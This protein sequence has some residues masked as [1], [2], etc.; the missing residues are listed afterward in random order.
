MDELIQ[1]KV[2]LQQPQGQ[3]A[4]LLKGRLDSFDFDKTSLGLRSN[5][6]P[7]TQH[8]NN[9]ID[10]NFENTTDPRLDP[11]YATYY[12]T[13]ARL[14]PRLPPPLTYTPG[15]SWQQQMWAPPSATQSLFNNDNNP[16]AQQILNQNQNNKKKLKNQGI[17][18][19]SQSDGNGFNQL[20]DDTGSRNPELRRP[21][22][23]WSNEGSINPIGPNRV[24]SPSR[25]KHL[26]DLIQDDFPRTPSPVFAMRQRLGETE[27][28]EETNRTHMSTVLSVLDNWED[29]KVTRS[30]STPPSQIHDRHYGI[31]FNNDLGM[32]SLNINGEEDAFSRASSAR[33]PKISTTAYGRIYNNNEYSNFPLKNDDTQDLQYKH[34]QQRMA[35]GAAVNRLYNNNAGDLAGIPGSPSRTPLVPYS[36]MRENSSQDQYPEHYDLR[37][38]ENKKNQQ[39]YNQMAQANNVPPEYMNQ[40]G[41][42][43]ARGGV[44]PG[45]LA[46]AAASGMS[47][48]K[49]RQILAQQQ[50]IW[51]REQMFR[52][53][54]PAGYNTHPSTQS[55]IANLSSVTPNHPDLNSSLSKNQNI[56]FSTNQGDNQIENTKLGHLSPNRTKK[57]NYEASTPN[58]DATV[59]RS[60]LLEDFRNNKNKKYEINDI[61]GSIVEFSG[62]QHGSRF[63]QQKLESAS[64]DEKQLVFDEILPNALQLM[65]DVFGNYVIQKFFEHGNQNQKK[66]LANQ[67]EGHILSLSLQMY[68]CRVVQ[69]GLEFVLQDQQSAMVKELDGNVL[70]CVKDQNG[71]H[72]I[73]KAIERIPTENIQF[74]IDA[75]HGQV[76]SLATH[77]YGCRVIQRIFEHCTEEQSKPLLD[78]L[79]RFTI[80]LIQDQYGNYVIQHVLEKG[81][82]L[83]KAMIV[84]KVRGQVLQMSKH[85]FASN[86]VEK[87]VAHG[88]KKDRQVLIEEVIQMRPDG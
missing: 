29:L 48:K 3:L 60:P 65:T 58:S 44:A 80:N 27:D 66:Q 47:E 39:F 25:R 31:D 38:N 75:F 64:G 36:Q 46:A 81:R 72:V 19:Y 35:V 18:N 2:K 57:D 6:A 40:Q 71:N 61:V 69:K 54:F 73:Q 43:P 52:R 42:N 20:N 26:V 50:Q 17:E 16:L 12:H 63:I 77:P 83:D 37:Y 87:C 45:L 30:A 76:Y 70:K 28:A 4:D 67:M 11:D 15:Q 55:P 41:F 5:S 9:N 33:P 74:I 14:D 22:P 1:P 62:D 24:S 10:N 78:E 8:F 82:P 7:P 53:D 85:K 88:S 51:L 13:H 59:S 21:Q 56:N 68:G 34:L 79:H 84:V 23:T 32:R 49:F 86:V